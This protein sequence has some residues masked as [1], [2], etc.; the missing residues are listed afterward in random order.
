LE[1]KAEAESII[2]EETREGLDFILLPDLSFQ[3]QGIIA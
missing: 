2:F 3:N 1:K